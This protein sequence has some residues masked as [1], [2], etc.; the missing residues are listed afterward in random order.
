MANSNSTKQVK[1]V[2]Q[3]SKIQS[4]RLIVEMRQHLKGA[5]GLREI[6]QLTKN[7]A[8]SLSETKVND[9]DLPAV[10]VGKKSFYLVPVGQVNETNVL[11]VIKSVLKVE[12]TKRILAKKM[13][14]RLSYSDFCET[15]DVQ[16]K[17]EFLIAGTELAGFEISGPQIAKMQ[18][19]LYNDYLKSL[20]LDE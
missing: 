7:F 15:K 4:L 8:Y 1:A 16:E 13:A 2:Q 9:S 17:V 6:M 5:G 18:H 14:K 19:R 12:D 11:N 20:G 10:K 3:V